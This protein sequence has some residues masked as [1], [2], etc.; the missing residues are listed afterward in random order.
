MLRTKQ[1][2][3]AHCMQSRTGLPK[4][5]RH[6]GIRKL[7]IREEQGGFVSTPLIIQLYNNY[8]NSLQSSQRYLRDA[9]SCPR[10]RRWPCAVFQVKF[11]QLPK[12][13]TSS[14]QILNTPGLLYAFPIMGDV[15]LKQD[16]S[17]FII[18]DE[19]AGKGL[20]E[21]AFD[22]FR[23]RAHHGLRPPGRRKIQPAPYF[24]DRRALLKAI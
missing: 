5:S 20:G 17:A 22:L 8:L 10:R 21:C 12:H 4:D 14:I 24:F 7:S 6:H 1:R 16:D 11:S 13:N 23:D 2:A 9:P 19:V 18:E 15:L 3:C